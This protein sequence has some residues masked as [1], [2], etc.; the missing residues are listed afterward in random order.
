MQK[1]TVGDVEDVPHFMGANTVRKPL[2][3]A[4]DG[5]GFAMTYFELEP[6]EAFSGGLH[7]HREQEELFY[8]LSGTAT[9]ETRET[10][11]GESESLE[12]SAGEAIHFEAGDVY[13][14]G[15]NEGTEGV[16]GFAVGVPGARH[17]WDDVEAVVEC[18]DCEK[19]TVHSVAPAEEGQRMPDGDVTIACEECGR[20][21]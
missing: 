6:G 8:V 14:T 20:E 9:F 10:P 2:S 21:R 4:I 18:S 13:Q 5:M 3:R 15:R 1:V 17:E 19:G 12:V 7:T 16:V 11:D